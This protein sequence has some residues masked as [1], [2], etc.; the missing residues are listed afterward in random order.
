MRIIYRRGG[1]HDFIAYLDDDDEWMPEKLEK[2]LA[3]FNE[4]DDD[5]AFVV[6]GNIVFDD[7]KNIQK[8]IW[9]LRMPEEKSIIITASHCGPTAASLIRTKCLK[10]VGG[11]D[12]LMPARQDLDLYIRLL[13]RYKAEFIDD[14][15]WI[16]HVYDEDEHIFGN[17]PNR[18][19][20]LQRIISK[21]IDYLEDNPSE[22]WYCIMELIQLYIRENDFRNVF[23][24]WIKAVKISPLNICKST[25]RIPSFWL[26]LRHPKIHSILKYIVK[27]EQ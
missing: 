9:R 18:I 12:E 8:D 2:Q 1:G 16:Y 23:M 27:G 22:Y 3:K 15:L 7:D 17:M 20:A 5:T 6:C 4:C 21:N 25:Y 26:K 11:F 14:V 19:K 24:Y 13:F 10:A